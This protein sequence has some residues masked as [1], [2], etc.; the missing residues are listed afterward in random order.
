MK[1][2]TSIRKIF[3]SALAS[4]IGFVSCQKDDTL[5]YSNL[6][7][8]NVVDGVFISDQ[9]NRFD[10]RE[11]TCEGRLDTM[12]RAIITCDVLAK[13]AESTYD[14]RL[15]EL[16]GVFT[17]AP[18][19]SSAVTDQEVFV[20]DPLMVYEMWYAG[21]YINMYVLIPFKIGSSQVH[22]INLVRND[23]DAAPG[24]YEFTLKHNAFGEVASSGEGQYTLGGTYMSFPV[25]GL[26]EGDEADIIIHWNSGEDAGDDADAEGKR[27]S[28]VYKWKSGGFEQDMNP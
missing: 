23:K 26:F 4:V 16:A 12:K 21:G 19:D 14:I 6:T 13:T 8:G 15:T 10:I 25:V 28:L 24:T 11:Q 18:V 20:E 9:G 1:I 17:K 5:Y 27:N 3:L 22:L 7:M 2:M